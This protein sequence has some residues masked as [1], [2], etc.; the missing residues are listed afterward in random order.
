MNKSYEF[1]WGYFAPCFGFSLIINRG[2]YFDQR[3][4]LDFHFIWGMLHILLPFTTRIP[5][6]CD[7]PRYGIQIHNSSFWLHLGGKMNDF[8]QCDSKWI[9]WDLPIFSWMFDWHRIQLPDKSWIPYTYEDRARARTEVYPYTYT[10]NSGEI[11]GRTASCFVEERQW[12]RKWLPC[13]KMNKRV[14]DIT[15][16]GEIG[17]KSGSWKGGTTGCGYNL[18]PSESMQDCLC[19]MEKERK[20]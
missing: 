16:S 17:E 9:T 12:H 11:Q 13:V 18:L 4:S 7:T 19:R 6:S 1:N 15:F 14:I 2:G 10:L 20:F 5:E 3:Y 8:E